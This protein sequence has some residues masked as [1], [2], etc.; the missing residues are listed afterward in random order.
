MDKPNSSLK[1]HYCTD[2]P[3]LYRYRKIKAVITALGLK[4]EEV[5]RETFADLRGLSPIP[6]L[7]LLETSEGNFS[8][9]NTIIRFLA[10][11]SD[12]RLYAKDNPYQQALI[13]QWL[14]LLQCDFDTCSVAL[15]VYLDGKEVDIETVTHDVEKF[16]AHLNKH[17][18]NRKYL[19]GDHISLADLA[20]AA[21]IGP[22]LANMYG[23]EERKK[24]SLIN[25]WY[26]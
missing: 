22:V 3:I 2:L 26:Q 15:N 8:S 13:D 16:L 20:V 5:P 19:V 7:P 14:D 6:T 21:T 1:L 17:L 25:K 9:S 18:K 10:A 24:Y 23:E 4:V 11:S 12:Y